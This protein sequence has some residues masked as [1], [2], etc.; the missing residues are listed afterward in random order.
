MR[1]AAVY[2]LSVVVSLVFA[3]LGFYY[4]LPNVYHPLSA[5]TVLHTTP[6]LTIAAVFI[7]LAVVVIVLGRLV[8]PTRP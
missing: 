1:S 4:L 7:V 2:Y 6:H 3:F 8:R 5:D